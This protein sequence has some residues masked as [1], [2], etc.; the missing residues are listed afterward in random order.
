MTEILTI[1]EARA[2]FGTLVRRAAHGHEETVITDHG[3]VAAVIVNAADLAEL[4]Y[5]LEEARAVA[6]H[7]KSRAAGTAS[8]LPHDEV[9]RRL[10]L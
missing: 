6:D 2:Q 8:F 3:H 1:T 4:R 5:Q 9:R 7:D 10:G